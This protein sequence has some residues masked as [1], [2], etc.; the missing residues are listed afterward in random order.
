MRR[1]PRGMWLAIA[2]SAIIPTSATVARADDRE[3]VTARAELGVEYDDNVHRAETIKGAT[4]ATGKVGSG[5]A[6]GVVSLSTSSAL[7]QGQD[8]AFSILGAGK[9]FFA[10]AARNENVYVVEN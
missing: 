9:L 1:P 8:V 10:P 2:A 7:S 5:L 3:R 4:D 6:R